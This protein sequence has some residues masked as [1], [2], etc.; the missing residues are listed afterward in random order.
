MLRLLALTRRETRGA[1]AL[2]PPGFKRRISKGLAK[3]GVPGTGV[4]VR[5]AAPAPSPRPC[6]ELLRRR[7]SLS[8]LHVCRTN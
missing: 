8:K 5:D 7:Y 4:P 3:G 2:D 6:A 1:V